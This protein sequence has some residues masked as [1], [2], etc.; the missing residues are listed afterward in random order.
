MNAPLAAAAQAPIDP[1][2]ITRPDPALM[3]YYLIVSLLT[4]PGFV[5]AILPL[6]FKYETLR[7]RF[8]DD[9]ISIS[10]GILFRREVHLTYRRIQDI[11]LTRN[12]LQRWMGLATVSVQTASGS[13]SP[14]ATID[15]ILAADALRDFLYA[16]M[17]G[18]REHVSDA[19]VSSAGPEIAAN[20]QGDE[21][22][23]LLREI[24]DALRRLAER[25]EAG[26]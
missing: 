16:K 1:R 26:A 14:E 6:W 13:S 12:L 10:W 19:A 22:L 15:G 24:R 11:H 21:P 9:G 5:V 17:R 7:Y 8:D 25:R 4:G 3:K 18:V 20:G 2:Q 23:E